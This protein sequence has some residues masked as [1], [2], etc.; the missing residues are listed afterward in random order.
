MCCPF[1]RHTLTGELTGAQDPSADMPMMMDSGAGAGEDP[2]GDLK[3]LLAQ[4]EEHNMV[5]RAEI[6]SLEQSIGV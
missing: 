4:M 5:L 2:S 6:N 1:P 3:H